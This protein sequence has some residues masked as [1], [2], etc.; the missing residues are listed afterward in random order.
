MKLQST[1][2]LPYLDWKIEKAINSL[3]TISRALVRK[4]HELK[5]KIIR[6]LMNISRCKNTFSLHDLISNQGKERIAVKE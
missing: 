6:M 3:Q 5:Y 1:K 2:E 4:D